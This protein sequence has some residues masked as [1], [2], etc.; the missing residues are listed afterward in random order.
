MT[1]DFNDRPGSSVVRVVSGGGPGQLRS[2]AEVVADRSR[3]SILHDGRGQEIDH[4]LVTPGLRE[5]L[6]DAR[7][8][9]EDLRDHGPK[10]ANLPPLPESD[11]APLV[12]S[13]A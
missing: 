5:R 2:C 10:A 11:H 8:L 9:N 6:T 12:A 1:G 4:I 7:F 13:F 3:F